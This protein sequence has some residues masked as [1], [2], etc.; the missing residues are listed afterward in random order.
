MS[1]PK[2]LINFLYTFLSNY[3]YV[4]VVYGYIRTWSGE[5]AGETK[6]KQAFVT[7]QEDVRER[8]GGCLDTDGGNR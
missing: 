8:D 3:I 6:Q 4:E 2:V 7:A 1:A 5:E